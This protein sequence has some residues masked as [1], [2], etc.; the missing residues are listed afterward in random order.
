MHPEEEG[1][2]PMKFDTAW[3]CTALR[4]AR[5]ARC[6][7]APLAGLLAMPFAANS[8]IDHGVAAR[9]YPVKPIRFVVAAPPG[10]PAD[11]VTRLIARKLN[12]AW[13][14]PIVIDNRPGANGIIGTAMTARAAPD[15]YT[16]V[17]A[18]AGLAVNPSLYA[19]VPYDPVRDFAPIT[20]AISVP[21]VLVV[22]YALPFAAV[23]DLVAA[24]RAKPGSI[25]FASAGKGTSGHLALELLQIVS[26]AQFVHGPSKGSANA[27]TELLGGQSQA[28][29]AIAV[30]ALPHVRAGRVKALAVTSATRTRA[31]PELPT[32]IEA[33]YPGFEVTS[34]YGV[35]APAGTSPVVVAKI[36]KEIV[37]VLRLADTDTRLISLAAD[38]VG[39]NPA[40]FARHIDAERR[41]WAQLIKQAGIKAD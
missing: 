41:K 19:N 24:A 33:G 6:L 27:L 14:Q 26:H 22:H 17:M 1:G 29:F 9:A 25:T 2:R 31:A 35:L 30:S 23:G 8:G 36:H 38:P 37:R 18:A 32:V 3:T 28:L 10:G 39:S 16:L 4:R 34:W 21:N 5:R 11:Q 12:E 15:G 20:Q 7:A 40:A 13:Q